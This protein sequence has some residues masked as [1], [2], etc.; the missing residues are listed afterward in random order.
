MA[1]ADQWGLSPFLDK[2]AGGLEPAFL[3]LTYPG[4]ADTMASKGLA[5][6]LLGK[7][8]L[9]PIQFPRWIPCWRNGELWNR[10]VEKAMRVLTQRLRGEP[11]V[12]P[13]NSQPVRA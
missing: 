11:G 6:P 12:H 3:T 10:G 4:E 7:E 13:E 5:V 2:N 9:A 8:G 1:I